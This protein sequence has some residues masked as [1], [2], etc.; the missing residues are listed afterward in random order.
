ML[1]TQP[2]D[3][4]AKEA[5]VLDAPVKKVADQRLAVKTPQGSGVL[6]VYAD[7]SL[8]TA[9]PEVKRILIV[10]HGTLRNADVY[11]ADGLRAVEEAGAAGAGSLVVAPQFLTPADVQAFK[12]APDTLAWSQEGWKGGE[13]ALS[14]APVS[15]FSAMDALLEHF[16]DRTLY[17]ALAEVVVSGHSAGAQIVQRYAVA[18]RAEA[19]LVKAGIKVR[20]VVANPSTYLYF[21][22]HRPDAD[23]HFQAAV[24]ASC[25]HVNRWKYGME[26]LPAYVSEQDLGSIEARYAAR[27]VTYLLGMAD[28]NP[29]THFIDRSCPAMAQ[30]PYRLARGLAYFNYMQG[31]HTAGL[32]QSVVEVP[33][34]GHD[35]R[36]MYGSACGQ[37][38]LFGQQLPAACPQLP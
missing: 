15:S 9:A 37:A 20:Y 22:N 4:F 14:P 36:G 8:S 21:D 2:Y 30:G 1:A 23:G 27:K 29:Y 7:H 13:P 17:P 6:P 38:V 35:G 33:G 10:V 18:G 24:T 16:T 12:L 26:Q 3:A 11:F 34:I 25:P 28:T 19:V 31:R 32:N 5:S